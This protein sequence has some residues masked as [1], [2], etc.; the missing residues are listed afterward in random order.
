MATEV[1]FLVDS[2]FYYFTEINQCLDKKTTFF[3]YL[4][5]LQKILGQFFG[6]LGPILGQFY[7][8]GPIWGSFEAPY[9][10]EGADELCIHIWKTL[11]LLLLLQWYLYQQVTRGL[12]YC[13]GWVGRGIQHPPLTLYPHT[14]IT[15]S[16][17]QHPKCIFSHFSTWALPT[18]WQTNGLTDW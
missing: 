11:F 6:Q 13:A 9:A 17:P 14:H 5:K 12:Q 16:Q 10:S 15:Q 1:V 3:L 4:L 7:N 2:S 18:D 8:F